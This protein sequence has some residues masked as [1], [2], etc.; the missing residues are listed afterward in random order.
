MIS[1]KNAVAPLHLS[2]VRSRVSLQ[3]ASEG[4]RFW[5][6]TAVCTNSGE[7]PQFISPPSRSR[8]ETFQN[9]R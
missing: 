1:Q 8:L 4:F 3:A 5:R 7:L 9:G 2:C 6:E